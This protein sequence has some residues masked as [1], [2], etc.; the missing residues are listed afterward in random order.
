MRLLSLLLWAL[1]IGAIVGAAQA[2]GQHDIAGARAI[3]TG[4]VVFAVSA[5]A[6]DVRRWVSNR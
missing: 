5:V 6:I 3:S 2:L 1:V 4:G